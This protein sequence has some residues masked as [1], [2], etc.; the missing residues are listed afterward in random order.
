MYLYECGISHTY[1]YGHYNYYAIYKLKNGSYKIYKKTFTDS[2][3]YDNSKDWS[4]KKY[5][6]I[7]YYQNTIKYNE[8][9]ELLSENKKKF[10]LDYFYESY[11]AKNFNYFFDDKTDILEKQLWDIGEVNQ[12]SA[13]I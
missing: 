10:I 7:K 8:K 6:R 12:D 11:R 2:T 1:M 5:N 13:N 9:I 4:L 3:I